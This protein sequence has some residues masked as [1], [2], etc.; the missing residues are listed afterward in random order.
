MPTQPTYGPPAQRPIQLAQQA[1]S[2]SYSDFGLLMT[3]TELGNSFAIITLP[4][5]NSWYMDSG[6]AT[7]ITNSSCTLMPL[8]NLSANNHTIVCNGHRIPILAYGQSTLPSPYP[9]LT[10][11]D[12]LFAPHII[13]NLNY[14]RKFTID[15]NA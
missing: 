12:V 7:H 9:P 5:G 14:V 10:L 3:P 2:A 6:A 4:Q 8:F 1:Y 13:K 11:C 15:K